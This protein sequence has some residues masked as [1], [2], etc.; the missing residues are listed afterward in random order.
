MQGIGEDTYF[1]PL[2]WPC[3][4]C[5]R[6]LQRR[7]QTEPRPICTSV[8]GVCRHVLTVLLY[9]TGA[10][11]G[12]MQWAAAESCR[13]DRVC[14]IGRERTERES[15]RHGT[16]NLLVDRPDTRNGPATLV[17]ARRLT[18]ADKGPQ[19]RFAQTETRRSPPARN[20]MESATVLS[21]VASAERQEPL[22]VAESE[23]E[24]KYRTAVHRRLVTHA[25]PANAVRQA[26]AY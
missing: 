25:S 22:R 8:P 1:W 10:A 9:R 20:R 26:C 12:S 19:P 18:A 14:C 3:R 16:I 6:K 5:S 7:V 24:R 13:V 23:A 15:G 17:V 11:N 21:G 4:E 2:S